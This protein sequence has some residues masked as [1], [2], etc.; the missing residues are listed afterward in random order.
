VDCA[1]R[2]EPPLVLSQAL[3]L[4]SSGLRGISTD[5]NIV[6]DQKLGRSAWPEIGK[7]IA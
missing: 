6:V 5:L 1:D 2:V 4:R 3:F 7:T